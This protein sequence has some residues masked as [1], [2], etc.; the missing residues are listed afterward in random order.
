[1]NLFG[2]TIG[3]GVIMA[4]I[5]LVFFWPFVIIWS[6]NTLFPALLIPY[7]FWTWL[8]MLIVSAT[9]GPKMRVVNKQ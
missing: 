1:M 8:S 4:L 2:T 9:F 6:L 3:V 7:T 5:L